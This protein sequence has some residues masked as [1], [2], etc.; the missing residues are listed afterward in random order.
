MDNL[1]GKES[2]KVLKSLGRRRKSLTAETQRTL[3]GL[4]KVKSLKLKN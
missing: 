4:R 2:H 1:H 3:K